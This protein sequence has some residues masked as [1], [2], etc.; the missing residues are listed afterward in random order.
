MYFAFQK[1]E[2]QLRTHLLYR[3]N[4]SEIIT[5]SRTVH[6]HPELMTVFSHILANLGSLVETFRMFSL[7]KCGNEEFL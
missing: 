3:M 5:G 7:R 4:L 6:I 1:S 2:F